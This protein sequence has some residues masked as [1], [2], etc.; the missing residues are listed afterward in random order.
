MNPISS[1]SQTPK[2]RWQEPQLLSQQWPGEGGARAVRTR[3]GDSSLAPPNS[4][5]GV[6]LA[7]QGSARWGEGDARCADS[8]RAA[9]ATPGSVPAICL[10]LRPDGERGRG[11]LTEPESAPGQG[12]R[13]RWVRAQPARGQLLSPSFPSPGR[14]RGSQDRYSRPPPCQ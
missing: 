3:G 14:A 8:V 5:A 13:A 7:L 1:G 2:L 11:A 12:L 6:L 9:A 10:S 4:G